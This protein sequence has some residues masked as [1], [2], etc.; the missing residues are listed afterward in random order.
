[1]WIWT[2]LFTASISLQ[3]PGQLDVEKRTG[4]VTPSQAGHG[5]GVGGSHLHIRHLDP[6][7]VLLSFCPLCPWPSGAS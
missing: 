2:H 7:T 6:L 4:P 5:C 3:H 1:M